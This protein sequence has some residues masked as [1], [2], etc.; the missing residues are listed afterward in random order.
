MSFPEPQNLLS[1]NGELRKELQSENCQLS[2]DD[3]TDVG[4]CG[5]FINDST[6][7]VVEFILKYFGISKLKLLTNNPRKIES[8]G[9]IH[10]IERLP[11]KIKSNP[12][13]EGYLKVKKD[14]MGHLL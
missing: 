12:H 6:Y 8:L 5:C 3:I 10:I 7:E 14:Q 13:N 4:G 11:I 9:D 1:E 2:F